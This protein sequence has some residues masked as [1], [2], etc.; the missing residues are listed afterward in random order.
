MNKT[1]LIFGGIS[2]DWFG[3]IV[4][5][6]CLT[7]VCA[8][9]LLRK[10]QKESIN[11]VLTVFCVGAPIAVILARLQ[12]CLSEVDLGQ[13]G[14]GYIFAGMNQGGYGLYGAI[15]GVL[16]AVFISAAVWQVSAGRLADCVA[17]VGGGVIAAGRFATR[18]TPD[19]RGFALDPDTF[20]VRSETDGLDYLAVYLLDG[21]VEIVIFAVCMGLFFF[22]YSKEKNHRNEGKIAMVFL[23]LHGLNQVVMDSLR[24]DSLCLFNND[25]IKASQIIGILSWLVI[26]SIFFYQAV[27]NQKSFSKQYWAI[28]A[29]F[30]VL[31]VVSI[32]KEYRV[33]SSNYISAHVTMGI[34]MI[35]MAALSMYIFFESE[36]RPVNV[37]TTAASQPQ[38]RRNSEIQ[39]VRSAPKPNSGR[40]VP[41]IDLGFDDMPAAANDRR[42][43]DFDPFDESEP[44]NDSSNDAE[45][46]RVSKEMMDEIRR[47]FDKM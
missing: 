28:I 2:V 27:K 36:K 23:M 38:P 20:T 41:D 44:R 6:A 17:A 19:E 5:A 33:G 37:K 13:T 43:I 24:M 12:Y 31:I 16:A 30:V 45:N 32:S 8:A 42:D 3:V 18:L 40:D 26:I 14:A 34:C 15:V 7:G 10:Y 35:I 25:F 29:A 22:I 39:P 9:C 11:D 47:Q 46:T 1:A 4:A 21:M